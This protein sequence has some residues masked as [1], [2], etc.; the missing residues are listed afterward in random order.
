MTD[1]PDVPAG[2]TEPPPVRPRP[3]DRGAEWTFLAVG[4]GASVFYLAVGRR[5]W[6]FNDEWDFLAGRTI[7]SFHSLFASHN[8]HWVTLPVVV[9]R[10]MW[11]IFGLRSYVPYQV[12]IVGLHFLAAWLI[13]RVMV[14]AHAVAAGRS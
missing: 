4:V 5:L 8:G 11:W 10:V 3:G 7:G 14:R 1:I 13:R 9:Y 12:L 6:F 2:A